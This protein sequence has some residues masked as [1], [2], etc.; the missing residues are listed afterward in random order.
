MEK[1][2]N[3]N[4]I[5]DYAES[6]SVAGFTSFKSLSILGNSLVNKYIINN[7]N[8]PRWK[9]LSKAQKVSLSFKH[10]IDANW[11]AITLMFSNNFIARSINNTKK[12]DFIRRRIN[13]NFKNRLG[14]IPD[15]L[16]CIE[17]KNESFHIHGVIKPNEDIKLINKILK[18][19]A[20]NKKYTQNT[21]P[22]QYKL[23]C[24]KIYESQGWEKYILKNLNHPKF[25]IYI[26]NT[27]IKRIENKHRELFANSLSRRRKFVSAF[28]IVE[29]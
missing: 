3:I 15:Y 10:I 27:M 16:F 24:T 11:Y 23:R 26:C 12:T 9:N 13:E 2:E 25:D 14:Y 4:N 29:N 21:L 1:K 22:E 8:I 19:T 7:I 18:S 5:N 6:Q 17:F 28:K 20:F